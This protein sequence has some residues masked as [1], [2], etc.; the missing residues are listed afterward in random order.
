MMVQFHTAIEA[1]LTQRHTF[2]KT[3]LVHLECMHFI[4]CDVGFEKN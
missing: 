1:V 3:Q 4:V 2:V